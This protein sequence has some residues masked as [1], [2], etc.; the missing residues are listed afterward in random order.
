MKKHLILLPIIMGIFFCGQVDNT[1]TNSFFPSPHQKLLGDYSFIE[2]TYP[3]GDSLIIW[4]TPEY[5]GTLII[6]IDSMVYTITRDKPFSK[7]VEYIEYAFI[8]DGLLLYYPSSDHFLRTYSWSDD[9]LTI[10]GD[11]N[12]TQIWKKQ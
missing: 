7:L 9:T 1:L 8:A 12:Y 10:Y 5:E 4:K 3:Y 11:Q 6:T 2:L